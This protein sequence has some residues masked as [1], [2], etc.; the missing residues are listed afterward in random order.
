MD[1]P[2]AKD[3]MKDRL[4]RI[5]DVYSKDLDAAKVGNTREKPCARQ[6]SPR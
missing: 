1:R 5:L 4:P 2:S 3:D 6:S